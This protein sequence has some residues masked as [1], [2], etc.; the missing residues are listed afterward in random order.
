MRDADAAARI[1]QRINR[2]IFSTL[3]VLPLSGRLDLETGVRQFPVPGL[4]YL[5]L[6]IP[7]PEFIDVLAVFH[8]SRDPGT[9]RKP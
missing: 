9:K 4:A 6:Y 2:V 8:T 3:S 1:I 7:Q 5:V